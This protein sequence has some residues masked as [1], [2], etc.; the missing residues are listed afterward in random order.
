MIKLILLSLSLNMIVNTIGLAQNQDIMSQKGIS[1]NKKQIRK[2][3][4]EPD[5]VRDDALFD[6]IPDELLDGEE[7]Y[8]FSDG[9]ILFKL[10][11]GNG[12]LYNSLED[13][14]EIFDPN[15]K[16]GADYVNQLVLD[17]KFLEQIP[18]LI[19]SLSAILQT[20]LPTPDSLADL[21]VLD[22]AI[23]QIGLINLGA[24]EVLLPLVAYCG[25]VIAN[26]V[27]GVWEVYRE[28]DGPPQLRIKAASGKLY[29]PYV[30][31]LHEVYEASDE[32]SFHGM[33]YSQVKEPFRLKAVG[34][35]DQ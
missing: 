25:Q 4:A 13:I 28:N 32:F 16:S 9:R 26:E 3:L 23:R 18:S 34:G 17:E 29:D 27:D 7:V 24:E 5:A 19:S 14:L 2:L 33:I 30:H 15:R 1:V 35:R 12:V 10:L 22:D 8:T 31:V 20:Q 11:E 21:Q 6:T